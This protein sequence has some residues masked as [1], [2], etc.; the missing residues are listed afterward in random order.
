MG[1]SGKDCVNYSKEREVQEIFD[2]LNVIH[3]MWINHGK[4][5]GRGDYIMDYIWEE[6]ELFFLK[7]N[8]CEDIGEVE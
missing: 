5:S 6:L 1:H 2:G 4:P 3:L 7:C 8:A